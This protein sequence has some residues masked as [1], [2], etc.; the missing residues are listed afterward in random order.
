VGSL[1]QGG[2]EKQ[3]LY[4]LIALQRLK[5]PFQ[6][7]LFTR[8]DYYEKAFIEHGF[9][10]TYIDEG[11]IFKRLA[12]LVR[13][14][15]RF[16][17]DFI[18]ATH[19]F[20]SFYAGM[21]GRILRI[22][23]IGA[24]RGD[25]NHDLAG[26]RKIWRLFI[27]L[28]TNYLANSNNA[29]QNAIDYGLSPARVYVLGNVIDVNQ[30]DAEA[31]MQPQEDLPIGKIYIT[32]VARLIKVK[33][34]ERFILA[35]AKARTT[36]PELTGV[37]I[38]AGPEMGALSDLAATLGL[39]KNQGII[40]LGNRTDIPQLLAQSHIFALTSDQEGFPNV[41]LEAM[42]ASL[43]VITTPAG[44]APQLI[45]DGETG[46]VVAF[47]NLEELAKK[48]EYL[49]KSENSRKRLGINGRR[50]VIQYYH[51]DR[52]DQAIESLYLSIIDSQQKQKEQKRRTQGMSRQA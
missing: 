37:I 16:Q 44:E 20:T 17:P 52:L 21:V 46:Y 32:I 38:G 4:Y 23:S 2:A 27:F 24:I 9:P 19:F 34:L 36:V 28:P 47:D 43:P 18:Q 14:I 49:A 35:I 1:S 13:E 50:Q 45:Q 5:Y 41:I 25:F 7:L 31:K 22:P 42:A 51:L 8:S 29:R 15:R 40:F 6:V 33:R 39:L 11:S 10:I 3:L 12:R 48:V 26:I 30:F